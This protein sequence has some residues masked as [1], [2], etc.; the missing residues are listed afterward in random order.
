MVPLPLLRVAFAEMETAETGGAILEHPEVET[1]SS[2]KLDQG[3]TVTSRFFTTPGGYPKLVAVIEKEEP[4][5]ELQEEDLFHKKHKNSSPS[6]KA[7]KPRLKEVKLSAIATYKPPTVHDLIAE[8][9][10]LQE[11]NEDTIVHL[12][13]ENSPGLKTVSRI[14]SLPTTKNATQPNMQSSHTAHIN[15]TERNLRPMPLSDEAT[16]YED[17]HKITDV[18]DAE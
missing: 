15:I 3:L 11:Q 9:Q 8:K 18:S 7:Q 17:Q 10:K 5:V 4:W 12:L 6:P 16:D 2:Y 1:E 14:A 13:I